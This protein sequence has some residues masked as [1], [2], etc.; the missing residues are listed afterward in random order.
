[1]NSSFDDVHQHACIPTC[2]NRIKVKHGRSL[3]C[4]DGEVDFF[5]GDLEGISGSED[6]DIRGRIPSKMDQNETACVK[7]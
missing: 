2:T 1:M 3:T 4:H 7:I 6:L 5:V